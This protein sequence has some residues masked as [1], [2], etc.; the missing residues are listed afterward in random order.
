[1]HPD[2]RAELCDPV[3][4]WLSGSRESD[5]GDDLVKAGS[6]VVVEVEQEVDEGPL[7]GESDRYSSSSANG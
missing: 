2:R 5:A 1:L 6:D 7:S 3:R 4:K